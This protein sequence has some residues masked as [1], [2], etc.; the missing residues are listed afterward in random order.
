[1]T[2]NTNEVLVQL[3]V[4]PNIKRAIKAMAFERDETVRSLILR[5][6]RDTGLPIAEAELGDRREEANSDF[7]HAICLGRRPF[8]RGGRSFLRIPRRRL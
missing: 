5:A 6:L 1:M 7:G 4:S 3:K 2:R 8:L